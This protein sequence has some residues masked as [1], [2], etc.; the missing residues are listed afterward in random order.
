MK[1]EIILNMTDEEIRYLIKILKEKKQQFYYTNI[2]KNFCK[3]LIN[4][5]SKYL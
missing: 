4:Y 1:K 3:N 5:L 2:Y